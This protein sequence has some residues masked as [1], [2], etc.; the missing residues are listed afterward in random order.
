MYRGF[1]LLEILVVLLIISSLT[2][3][4]LPAWQKT[5][6]QMILMKEQH[7]LYL[8]LRQ[9]QARVENS[10]EIWLLIANRDL[11]NKH[12]CLTAQVKQDNLCDCLNPLHCAEA[13]HAHF[14]YPYFPEQT[15]LVSKR[16][17][18]T[19]M[20]RL[21]GIRDTASSTCFVLQ[22]ENSRTVFS[23]FNVGS[24]KLKDY[25]TAS[26]CINDGG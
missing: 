17:Y 7:K 14:Y 10:S 18:P 4:A 1:T 16:Y 5:T 22:A 13:A 11:Q 26:A 9:I 15:M 12:W 6:G 24:L 8:F 3:L 20:T 23:F 19:E 2:L 25:Q 21:S